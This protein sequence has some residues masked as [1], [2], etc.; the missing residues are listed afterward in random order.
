MSTLHEAIEKNYGRKPTAHRAGRWSIDKRTF[1][2]LEKMG[3]LVDTSICPYMSWNSTRGVSGYIETDGY[4]APNEPY[5]PDI[6]DLTKKAKD[7][8]SAFKVLEVPVTGVKNGLLGSV[9][10]K[11]MGRFISVLRKLGYKGARN[12]SFRPDCRLRRNVFERF[13]HSVFDTETPF[14]NFMFHSSELALGASPYTIESSGLEI[15]KG[16]IEYVLRT[17]QSYGVKGITLSEIASHICKTP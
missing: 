13:V 12:S 10:L 8:K 11:G 5:Y 1:A 17:A 9:R 2:W 14:I 15:M 16:Q 4:D 3:Y 7:A 6:K